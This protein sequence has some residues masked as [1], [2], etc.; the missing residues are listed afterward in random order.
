MKKPKQEFV[1]KLLKLKLHDI[2][3][4]KREHTVYLNNTKE[5]LQI[6]VG[7]RFEVIFIENYKY[8]AYYILKPTKEYSESLSN[9]TYETWDDG[10]DLGLQVYFNRVQ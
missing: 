7:D 5:P 2:L 3:E 6:S 9:M 1:P 4:C 8:C 10:D